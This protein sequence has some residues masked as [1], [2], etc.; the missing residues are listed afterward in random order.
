MQ[1]Q[2]IIE[3]LQKENKELKQDINLTI[4]NIVRLLKGLQIM[5]P[6]NSIDFRISKLLRTLPSLLMNE[7]KIIEQFSF[8]SELGPII[9]KYGIVTNNENQQ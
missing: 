5:Q 4:L 3:Q 6:D 8:L 2:E 7:K 9:E 1:Q